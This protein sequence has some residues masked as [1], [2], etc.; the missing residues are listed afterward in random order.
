MILIYKCIS[1]YLASVRVLKGLAF[2]FVSD[3][4]YGSS[5]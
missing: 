4:V 3:H 2:F 5:L 1:E